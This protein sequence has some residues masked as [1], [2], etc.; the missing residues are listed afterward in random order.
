MTLHVY[1]IESKTNSKGWDSEDVK[2]KADPTIYLYG[3]DEKRQKVIKEIKGFRPYFYVESEKILPFSVS[4]YI[5]K[6]GNDIFTSI[7]GAKVRK[8]YLYNP[9][10]VKIVREELMI[11]NIKTWEDD[12][13][14]VLRFLIDEKDKL[15]KS[16]V[17]LKVSDDIRKL[18]LDIETTTQSGFPEPRTAKESITCIGCY[19]SYKKMYYVFLWH[20]TMSQLDN[21]KMERKDVVVLPYSNEHQMIKGF[22]DYYK[23]ISPD[24][25]LGWNVGEFDISYII[26]R[27]K[28]LKLDPNELAPAIYNNG[29]KR[30]INGVWFWK[31]EDGNWLNPNING[32]VI[33]DLLKYYKKINLNQLPSYSLDNISKE[34]LGE[35]KVDVRDLDKCW[36]EDTKK[37]IEYNVRD[38]ELCIRIEEKRELISFVDGLRQMVGCNFEDFHYFSRLVDIL[39]L[40]Y[41]KRNNIIL[42]SK[43]QQAGPYVPKDQRDAQYEGA[44]VFAKPGLYENVCNLD[45]KTLYPLIIKSMN[46]SFETILD[47]PN[48]NCIKIGDYYFDK[49]KVGILPAVIDDLL[50]V[51][52]GYKALRNKAKAGSDDYK[53][54]ANLYECAKF[55]VCTLYGV[56]ANASF[57]LFDIRCAE[58]ITKVGRDVIQ[59]TKKIIEDEGHKV[60]VIDTDSCFTYLNHHNNEKKECIGEGKRVEAL[61][62]TKYD[63]IVKQYNVTKHYLQIEF[64]KFFSKLLVGT[65]KRYAG[66]L[67]WKEGIEQDNILTIVGFEWIRSS[68]PKLT[69]FIQRDILQLVMEGKNYGYIRRYLIEKGLD[70]F[71]DKYLASDLAFPS[72]I[73]QAEYKVDLPRVRGYEWSNKNLKTNFGVGHKPLMMYVKAKDT[74]AVC[75]EYDYQF[76]EAK[77][78]G[79]EIDKLKMIERIIYMPQHTIFEALGWDLKKIW[80]ELKLKISG[81]QTLM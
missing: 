20:P 12:V 31:S 78:L 64:E 69:K 76:D 33:F 26:N 41:G 44:H 21:L 77:K 49:D 65:K 30:S 7:T 79:V 63:E 57:R 52:S 80:E 58:S 36:R 56:Q 15:E 6:V 45:L 35:G 37:F 22:L 8:L 39:V 24:M 60:V 23:S 19:D 29:S 75:F 47:K 1:Q 25:I 42:P 55:V 40:K 46:I 59:L 70:I 72:A 38:I 73:N 9:H 53:K 61:L 66:I 18:Y 48:N 27:M 16:G 28:N 43:I 13:L 14:F 34:E 17:M 5:F 68:T 62:N 71:N 54:Y 67:T 74:D 10:Y 2:I 3:R 11:H 51:S 50:K 32:V 81:Q 4:K